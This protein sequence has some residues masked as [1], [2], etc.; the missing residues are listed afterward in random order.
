MSEE[1]ENYMKEMG[2]V[3]H[4][5]TPLWPRANLS[6]RTAHFSKPPESPKQKGKIGGCSSTSFY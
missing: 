5:N 6:V 1:M 3:P 4:C 2:I